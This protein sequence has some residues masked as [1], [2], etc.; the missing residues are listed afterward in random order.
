MAEVKEVKKQD[1]RVHAIADAIKPNLSVED[2]KFLF[3]EPAAQAAVDAFNSENGEK[4][5][6]LSLDILKTAD[7]FYTDLESALIH[8]GGFMGADAMKADAS[9]ETLK[10]SITFGTTDFILDQKRAYSA[11][12]PAYNAETNPDAPQRIEKAGRA[13]IKRDVANGGAAYKRAV[14]AVC[15]YAGDILG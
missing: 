6:Q 11:H 15:D 1:K 12:N 10:G 14:Q 3:S 9:I 4:K 7:E 5:P 2:K 8:A 13:T